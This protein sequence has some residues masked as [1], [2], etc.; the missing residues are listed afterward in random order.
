MTKLLEIPGGVG[1]GGPPASQLSRF[2][3]ERKLSGPTPTRPSPQ[4][5]WSISDQETQ[6]RASTHRISPASAI[7]ATRTDIT[8]IQALLLCSGIK[9]AELAR[10]AHTVRDHPAPF[11]TRAAETA[12]ANDP[13]NADIAKHTALVPTVA[14]KEE[15]V[16]AAR[17]LAS[18]LEASSQ[19]LVKAMDAFRTQR[20]RAMH[21]RC[22]ALRIELGDRLTPRTHACAD[23]A[24]AFTREVTSGATLAVKAVADR[25]DAMGR[26]RRRRMRWLRRFGWMMLEWCVLG[27]MWWVW[28]VVVIVRFGLGC[29][30]GV[31]RGV[32]WFLWLD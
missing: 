32:R 3:A 20:V 9:A 28:L 11:L 4:R 31:V 5:H 22:E 6:R 10:R 26:A 30:R 7:A 21:Q 29:V 17:I 19:A 27:V 24:D 15:H 13:S 12:Q 25:V 16:L 2:P 18:D 8:R 23:D 1:R 14:R